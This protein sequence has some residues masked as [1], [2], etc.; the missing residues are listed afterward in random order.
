VLRGVKY[1]KEIDW[2][3]FGTLIYEMM[4]GLVRNQRRISFNDTIDRV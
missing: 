3:S 1:G 4:T 2:W